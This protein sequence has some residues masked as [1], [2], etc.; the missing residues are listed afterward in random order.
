MSMLTIYFHK[1]F[2]GFV[3]TALFLRINQESQLVGAKSLAL[4]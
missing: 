4:D 2:D 1:D 3:A